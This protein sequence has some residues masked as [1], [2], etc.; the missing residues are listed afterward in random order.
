[1]NLIKADNAWYSTESVFEP[2]VYIEDDIQEDVPVFWIDNCGFILIPKV[3]IVQAEYYFERNLHLNPAGYSTLNDFYTFLG[4]AS[5]I[6]KA[7][8]TSKNHAVQNYGWTLGYIWDQ[9]YEWLDFYH[10]K[11]HSPKGFDYYEFIFVP[12]PIDLT[13]PCS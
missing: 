4:I 7:F 5:K 1:M 2:P 9:G 8:R 12:E 13:A 10:Q 11:N 6:K 3:Q